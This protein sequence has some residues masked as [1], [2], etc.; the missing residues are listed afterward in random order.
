M[1]I[2]ILFIVLLSSSLI[3][4]EGKD[5]APNIDWANTII[6]SRSDDL[7][8]CEL[9]INYEIKN[10]DKLSYTTKLA[11]YDKDKHKTLSGFEMGMAS[12]DYAVSGAPKFKGFNRWLNYNIGVTKVEIEGITWDLHY[13]W[14]DR[15][16]KTS[17]E[18]KK[19]I[20]L[21]WKTDHTFEDDKVII[22]LQIK[23]IKKPTKKNILNF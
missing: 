1:E 17:D 20:K 23:W 12:V 9:K 7:A 22:K 8:H 16:N 14:G 15:D 10:F 21:P 11:F 18:Y 2:L 4:E 19:T 6:E 3:A 13:S 5:I